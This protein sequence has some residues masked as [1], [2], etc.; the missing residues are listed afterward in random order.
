MKNHLERYR[1]E[2]PDI[3]KKAIAL[4]E[5]L[6]V[7]LMPEGR[8]TGYKGAPSACI[9]EVG[10]LLS[11]LAAGYPNGSIA[12]FGTG[13][14]VGTAWLAYGLSANAKLY[15]AELDEQ[16]VHR[17]REL[18][19]HTPNIEIRH[20]D[21]FEVLANEMPFDLR[22]M[23]VGVRQ[24]LIPENWDKATEMVKVGG[25]IVFDDLTPL[26][27]WP[28]EWDEL[29]DRKREFALHNSRVV[30]TEVRTTATQ[31]AIIVTRIK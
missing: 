24:Y 12:E 21:C 1:I 10:R 7:P 8:P 19:T 22:F 27:L 14:G 4:A 5:E 26:E 30:G 13:A 3:V 18:F 17:T 9:S 20:G 23:D 15:S 31:A 25:K 2:I 16:L 29:V 6:G 11:V 28:S